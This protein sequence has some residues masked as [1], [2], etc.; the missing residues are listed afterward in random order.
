MKQYKEDIFNLMKDEL[1]TVLEKKATWKEVAD[2]YKIP[3]FKNLNTRQISMR[4]SLYKKQGT[5]AKVKL[6]ML[7][8]F[9]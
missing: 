7:Q 5:P 2:Y 1:S 6:W 3:F 4:V 9:C 8:N